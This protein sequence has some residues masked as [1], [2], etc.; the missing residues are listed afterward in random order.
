MQVYSWFTVFAVALRPA[1]EGLT[2][3]DRSFGSTPAGGVKTN[4][5]STAKIARERHIPRDS[6][7]APVQASAPHPKPL[8]ATRVE[9]K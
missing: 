6:L 3:T 5:A 4:G 2:A 9:R 8:P 1:T 7:S